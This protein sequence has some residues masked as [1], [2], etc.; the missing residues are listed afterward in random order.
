MYKTVVNTLTHAPLFA[1]MIIITALHCMQRGLS[2]RKAV[3]LSVR[4]SVR[5]SV[6]HTRVLL[7]NERKFCRHSYTICKENSY[8]FSDTKNGWWGRPLVPEM[9]GQTDPP[10]FKNGDFQSIFARSASALRPI[11]KEVQLSLI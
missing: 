9:L 4:P 2:C 11:A 7:Q 6:R 5:L 10:S 1:G 3:S 8:A